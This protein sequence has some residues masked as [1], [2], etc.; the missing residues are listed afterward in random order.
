M[1]L[2][3]CIQESGITELMVVVGRVNHTK[4][5]EAV[6]NPLLEWGPLEMTNPEK[7]Q[8]SKQKY[9]VTKKGNY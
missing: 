7:T 3:A 5:R 4:F 8:S 1:V 6:I 9:R 2:Q